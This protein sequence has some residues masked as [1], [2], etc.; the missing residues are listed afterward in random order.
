[1]INQLTI[2]GYVGKN[3]VNCRQILCIK[4]GKTPIELRIQWEGHKG[5]CIVAHAVVQFQLTYS[6]KRF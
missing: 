5:R 2:V 3:N 4:W 1:M 6:I